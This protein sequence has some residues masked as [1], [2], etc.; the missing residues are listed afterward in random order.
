MN[1]LLAKM[2]Q[3]NLS[4]DDI[5][6]KVCFSFV[7]SNDEVNYLEFYRKVSDYVKK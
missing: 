4:C 6:N 7:D 5:K 2:I 3:D 1:K